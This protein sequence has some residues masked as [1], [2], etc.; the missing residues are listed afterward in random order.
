MKRNNC[1]LGKNYG[2]RCVRKAKKWMSCQ[3]GDGW[4]AMLY[5]ITRQ[6]V[7]TACTGE[8]AGGRR[9]PA[10]LVSVPAWLRVLFAQTRPSSVRSRRR[11]QRHCRHSERQS[12]R[13]RFVLRRD[14]TGIGAFIGRLWPVSA[15]AQQR[16]QVIS[17]S[18]HPRAR[19]SGCTFFLK[20]SWRPET[21][22]LSK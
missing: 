21:V 5:G 17:R 10:V 3:K 18:E 1:Y 15:P 11:H 22:S 4:H 7:H 6:S 14:D 8:C 16:S 19:S 2:G 20:K 12:Q 9:G 13:D